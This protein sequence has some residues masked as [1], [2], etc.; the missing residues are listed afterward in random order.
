[1]R[2][3]SR[4]VYAPSV[5]N[6]APLGLK[7]VPKYPDIEKYE[8]YVYDGIDR[9]E[10]ENILYAKKTNRPV[11]AYTSSILP[12]EIGYIIEDGKRIYA[13]PTGKLKSFMRDNKVEVIEPSKNGLWIEL[14]KGHVIIHNNPPCI[15]SAEIVFIYYTDIAGYEE[16]RLPIDRTFRI[17]GSY[18]VKR[19][20]CKGDATVY[21][22]KLVNE[23]LLDVARGIIVDVSRCNKYN[24]S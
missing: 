13:V 8:N 20:Q 2:V 21:G 6:R 14:S 1:M 17:Q 11:R 12:K 23:E 22:L 16:T 15:E 9:K 18:G 24:K 10:Y 5:V 7:I 19:I 4:I 3:L